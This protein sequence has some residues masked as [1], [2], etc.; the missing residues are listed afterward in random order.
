MYCEHS[1]SQNSSPSSLEVHEVLECNFTMF[2]A[3]VPSGSPLGLYR[4]TDREIFS[5]TFGFWECFRMSDTSWL[6]SL[7]GCRS[8]VVLQS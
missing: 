2:P 3:F 7:Y 6:S 4:D 5:E 8:C 1:K